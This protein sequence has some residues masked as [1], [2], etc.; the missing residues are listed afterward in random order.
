MCVV[1]VCI[2]MGIYIYEYG[3]LNIYAHVH[4][5]IYTC[6]CVNFFFF[7]KTETSVQSFTQQMSPEPSS[8][9]DGA[10]DAEGGK[11]EEHKSRKQKRPG[12]G[13]CCSVAETGG[14]Q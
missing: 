2:D 1:C 8:M 4:I 10:V 5:Y 14:Q 12:R 3:H 7:L 13:A 6:V 11:G 9:P